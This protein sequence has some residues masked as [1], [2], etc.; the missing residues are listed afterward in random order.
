MER[1]V[2]IN[3]H[4]FRY[5][6]DADSSKYDI[7]LGTMGPDIFFEFMSPQ[8]LSELNKLIPEKVDRHTSKN[9]MQFAQLFPN[10]SALKRSGKIYKTHRQVFLKLLGF[11][12]ASKYIP[13]M[14][15]VIKEKVESWEEGQTINAL[16]EMGDVALKI[17]VMIAFGKDINN[18]IRPMNYIHKDGRIEQMDFYHFFPTLMYDLL[19]A[20]HIPINVVF[21]IIFQKGWLY[22]NNIN[23]KNCDELRSTM[24]DFLTHLKDED[25]VYRQLIDHEGFTQEDIFDDLIGLLHA[26]HETSHHTVCSVLYNIKKHPEWYNKLKTELEEAGVTSNCDFEKS[27]T[28]DV[29]H[30]SP[31]LAYTI[32]E[33]LRYDPAGSR[34]LKYSNLSD[35]N[36]C[37]IPIPKNSQIFISIQSAHYNKIQF[38]YP[39]KFLPER[40]DPQ[41]PTYY[42]GEEKDEPRHPHS[43][44]PFSFN[45][46]KCPGMIL[47]LIEVKTVVSYLITKIDYSIDEQLLKNDNARFGI[48]TNFK[49]DLKID[50]IR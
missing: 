41:S 37:N 15:H 19:I 10:T 33:T 39:N 21:P 9:G 48:Y 5:L 18:Q 3:Q 38:P 49:L 22:P 35:I 7:R 50:K 43:Y 47:A 36:I 11:N 24:K 42:I 26:A 8:A 30:D 40:F 29:I 25:S 16:A 14:L 4:R 2:G 44:I 12:Y 46:R 28:K 34:S 27:M 45:I 6:C 32:K 17:I 13:K 31:N 20:Q 1:L 23:Q